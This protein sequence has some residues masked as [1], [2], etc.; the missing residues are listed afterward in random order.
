MYN[1]FFFL[2]FSFWAFG[3][4]VF[5]QEQKI[6]V[7]GQIFDAESKESLPFAHICIDENKQC[8]SSDF[9]GFYTMKMD[10]NKTYTFS[11][12]FVGYATQ[13]LI[14]NINQDTSIYFYLNK[15]MEE[16]DKVFVIAKHKAI[17]IEQN[18]ST[19]KIQEQSDKNLGEILENLNGVSALKSGNS[20]SKPI[21]QGHIGNRVNIV[22]NG[23]LLG[24]QRW[25][26][27]HSPEINLNSSNTLELLSVAEAIEFANQSLGGVIAINQKPIFKSKH[28]SIQANYIFNSNGL[29]HYADFQIEK[30]NKILPFRFTASFQQN[31]D[32]RSPNYYLTNTG[33]Q[34]MALSTYFTKKINTVWRSQLF[35]SFYYDHLGILRASHLGNLTD[36][37]EALNRKIPFYTKENF[38]YAISFPKQKVMH[39]FIQWKNQWFLSEKQV[40]ALDYSFQ[41]NKREE[42]DIR[43]NNRSEI[44]A[45]S[46]LNY[47]NDINLNLNS[48][49]SNNMRLKT[50]IQFNYTDNS[51]DAKT[52][53]LPL[54]PDYRA[55]KTGAF[56]LFTITK[57]PFHYQGALRYTLNQFNVWAISRNLPRKIEK[58]HNIYH[59][60]AVANSLFF[61]IKGGRIGV[62]LSYINRAPAVNERFS[63]GLHQGVGGIEE[64]KQN[65]K[66]EHALKAQIQCNYSLGEKIELK[67]QMYYHK[68]FN[69]IYLQAQDK[70]R[71]TI[72]GAFPVFAYQQTQADIVGGDFSIAYNPIERLNTSLQYSI[73]RGYNTAQNIPL[74]NMPTDV[75]KANI[76]YELKGKKV[77][78]KP[79]ISTS[80]AY[81]FKQNHLL[82]SQDFMP[83][84]NAYFLLNL[85]YS[86]QLVFKKHR[87]Q[88]GVNIE[89]VLNQK[90][91]NYLNRLRYFADETGIN[92]K[93]RV[94]YF[95]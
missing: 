78:Q 17:K 56:A 65:L 59:N 1:K 36:L 47:S 76:S 14:T 43:R 18:L 9:D 72:R 7:Q 5:A 75:L 94:A 45:L 38:S 42:F 82:N 87:L 54:I 8:T 71:L 61:K 33:K 3:S 51:N 12:S 64:G 35:Y 13:T 21:V 88:L 24:S 89:N 60:T 70:F 2:F 84:P 81:H 62:E 85:A 80:M 83:A 44:P 79:K 63:F 77:F 34:N 52:G 95:F 23:A 16:I 68:I 19:E 57:R 49:F 27:D 15:N 28:H 22:N 90:Y 30:H 6:I 40:L 86:N 53:I 58:H 4:F 29:G 73:I 48:F 66:T 74:V 26:N 91:R 39:H 32:Y 37:K 46:L 11:V 67:G 20:G 10:K 92:V 41:I 50:G 69:Y 31:G 25:G 93:L 55:F